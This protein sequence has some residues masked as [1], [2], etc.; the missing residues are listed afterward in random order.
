MSIRVNLMQFVPPVVNLRPAEEG[1]ARFLLNPRRDADAHEAQES[2]PDDAKERLQKSLQSCLRQMLL[3][4]L[5][6]WMNMS[7]A[8]TT[9]LLSVPLVTSTPLCQARECK[10]LLVRDDLRVLEEVVLFVAPSDAAGQRQLV[11]RCHGVTA[12]GGW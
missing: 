1:C 6:G 11:S 5:I 2:V 4:L 10:D 9:I 7:E 12:F 3:R 8:G